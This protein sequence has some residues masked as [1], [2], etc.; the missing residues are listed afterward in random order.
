MFYGWLRRSLLHSN[1]V[2]FTKSHHVKFGSELKLEDDQMTKSWTFRGTV[3]ALAVAGLGVAWLATETPAQARDVATI[4]AAT[5]LTTAAVGAG[6]FKFVGSRKC[7][8]CHSKVFKSWEQ[9]PHAKAMEG[10]KPGERAEAKTKAGLDPQKDYTKDES[11]VACHV[12]G[13]GQAGGFQF[14]DDEKK[15]AKLA[16]SHGSVGCESCHGAG[17]A[18]AK[19]HKE[20]KK[21]K[22]NYKWSEMEEA[23]MIKI[24]EETCLGC[25][26][27]KS[28]THD[29][30]AKFDYEAAKKTGTHEN[31][32]LK[33]R[34]D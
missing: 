12:V 22:R 26:N 30:D 29:A 14:L 9:T 19:L 17:E 18:Y 32:G 23:G 8:M 6:D 4:D 13:W 31:F 2:G 3:V 11:C 34:E 7:K 27:E 33:Q 5:T 1:S 28:P 16:K 15:A 24:T 20:V 25:H 21:S 10:L